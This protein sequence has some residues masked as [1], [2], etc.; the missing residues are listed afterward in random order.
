M[1]DT[2][3]ICVAG[4]NDI[5]CSIMEYLLK[6]YPNNKFLACCNKNDK[7]V[8]NFQKSFKL[9]C[10]IH[11]IEIVSLESLYTIEDLIFLSLEYDQIIKPSL[12]KTRKLY[13]I[14][15][16]LL[17]AYKGMYTS[18]W[19]ILNDEKKSGVTLHL[20]DRGID[21]G[22]IID[23]IVFDLE[24]KM[25]GQ[26]LYEKYIEI[27]QILVQRNIK[28]ILVGQTESRPQLF[29]GS[30]YYSKSSID[31]RDLKIDLKK[32]AVEIYNQIRAFSFPAYQLPYL[33]E[34]PIYGSQILRVKSS[35]KPVT[36]DSED[37]FSL[38]INSIDYNLKLLKDRRKE[39]HQ[40]AEKGDLHK[41]LHFKANG[42]DIRQR[43]PEGWDIL[44]IAAYNGQYELLK[45]LILQES[46]DLNTV[47]NNGTTFIMYVMTHASNSGNLEILQYFI[48][49]IN[50]DWNRKDFFGKDIFEYAENYGNMKVIELLKE[51]KND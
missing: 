38:I 48:D 11:E 33:L 27:G 19:P 51:I 1:N 44:I 4:K 7:G 3:T 18:A 42:Y 8:N 43:S 37:D 50:I 20:I 2:H 25:N 41:I 29:L 6:N 13:N 31:Y 24:F 40:L 28:N 34:Y 23:Q 17:P 39:L 46:W 47:N 32:T 12:F 35:K 15:F 45:H 22:D 26:D 9:F 16:S 14:H 5:A 36:I 10:E 49:N 21:T 30:S